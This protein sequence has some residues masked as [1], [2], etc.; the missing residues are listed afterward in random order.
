MRNDELQ[1]RLSA[2]VACKHLRAVINI[3]PEGVWVDPVVDVAKISLAAFAMAGTV[4]RA[5]LRGAFVPAPAPARSLFRRKAVARPGKRF[6]RALRTVVR[7]P[8]RR[9]GL[10]ARFTRRRTSPLRLV[11]TEVR[12]LIPAPPPASRRHA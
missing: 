2:S 3:G 9:G 1:S 8:A 10:L 11:I 12:A 5:V 4:A 7:R 6:A